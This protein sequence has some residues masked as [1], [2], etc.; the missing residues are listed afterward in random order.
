MKILFERAFNKELAEQLVNRDK[1]RVQEVIENIEAS[2]SLNQIKNL[3][4]LTGHKTHFRIRVGSYQIGFEL[5]GDTLVLCTY[6][7]RSTIL[8]KFP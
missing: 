3:E 4:K 6:Q 1:A 2:Q 5:V 7:H 8:K